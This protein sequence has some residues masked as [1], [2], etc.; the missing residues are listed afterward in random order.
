MSINFD[1]GEEIILD[2]RV[3]VDRKKLWLIQLELMD[4]LLNVCERNNLK[5]FAV[6]GTLLGAVRHNGFIPWDD[7]MDF[8]MLREDYNKLCELSD[9]FK[10]PYFLQTT[11]TEKYFYSD[12]MRIRDSR[13]TAIEKKDRTID[14]NNGVYIDVFPF[15]SIPDNKIQLATLQ[16]KTKFM[17]FLVYWPRRVGQDDVISK[18]KK[19]STTIVCNIFGYDK[20]FRTYQKVCSRYNGKSEEFVGIVS[21]SIS[22]KEFYYHY[23]DVKDICYLSFEGKR[24][25]VPKG[26]ERCLSINYGDYLK[27]PPIEKRGC[28]HDD[29]LLIDVNTPYKQFQLQR[30]WIGGD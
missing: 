28:W 7:D 30:G 16:W 4:Q 25:P 19:F 13:F 12:V 26:Y 10:Y 15:D 8:G 20:I 2:Y 1:T 23:N 6:C 9:Q 5:V 24:I 3:T 27:L 29:L 21:G 22:H 11:L 14:C 17:K 18:I